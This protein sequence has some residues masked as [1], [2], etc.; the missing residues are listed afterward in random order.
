MPSLVAV[1]VGHDG[2]PQA[3]QQRATARA[4][5]PVNLEPSNLV[6]GSGGCVGVGEAH[7]QTV[8]RG[9]VLAQ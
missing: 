9:G 2:P 1:Q 5:E 7:S 6:Q 4:L 3:L 8:G